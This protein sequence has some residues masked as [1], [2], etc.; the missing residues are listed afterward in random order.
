MRNP[1]SGTI[2]HG[3]SAVVS[4]TFR[5]ANIERLRVLAVFGIV[6]FHT[7]GTVGRSIGYAGLPIFIM[8]FSALVA[9]KP[10]PEDFVPFAMKKARRL[11]MPWLFW[12]IV[13]I[14][15]KVLKQSLS[16]A[17]ISDTLGGFSIF[18]GA[19]I[20]LWYLPFA[21]VCGLVVHLVHRQTMRI[22]SAVTILAGAIAG[23][24]GL[25]ACSV[26]MSLTDLPAPVP[27]W[28]FGLPG[29][30]L[31]FAVGRAC[32]LLDRR[33]Q[34][35]FC[36]GIV[37]AVEGM[38]LLL[39]Y[40]GYGHMV[41]PYGIAMVLVCVAFLSRQRSNAQLLK[42]SSLAYGIYLVHPLV[43]S[44]LQTAGVVS[45]DPLIVTMIVFLISSAAILVIQKTPLRQ[46]V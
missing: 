46:F 12:S 40:L 8:I 9:H 25:F 35:E 44:V 39:F 7:E 37:L 28:L 23:I 33:L 21:F 34:K 43:D 17:D 13:Y 11:L 27:Q 42:F 19:R 36:F 2:F 6:W 31:G 20:H 45:G 29:V 18:V 30:A 3:E 1:L 22:S 26:A 5:I 38:C 14:V 32:A 10:E 41:V 16:G 24:L 15:C 4:E